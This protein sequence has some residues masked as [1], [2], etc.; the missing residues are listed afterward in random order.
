MRLALMILCAA[1]IAAAPSTQPSLSLQCE[2]L[3]AEWRE[4]FRAEHLT[5]IVSPPFVVAGDGGAARVRRYVDFTINASADALQRKFF[6]RGRPGDPIL[7]LLFESDEPYRRLAKKW[8]GDDD[9]SRFGYFRHDNI[10]VMNVGTGT[11][12][13]V[14]ELTHALISPDFPAV[15]S[16]F[17]EGLGSLFEQCTL[18]NGDIR[19]LVNWRLPDLQHAIRD[20]QLRSLAALIKDENFYN[21]EHVGLNYAQARYVLMFLQESDRLPRYYKLFR[22]TCADDATGLKQL[23][24]IIA[25]QSLE[26]FEKDWRKWV[27]KLRFE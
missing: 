14:H 12:T 19:G 20:D 1:C 6:D 17:N 10:M 25:P 22:D 15:P 9:I 24:Q 4:R 8:L 23:K 27:L 11:G 13:L 3:A 7:V 18:A 26:Q 21:E 16:W 2:T 5:A